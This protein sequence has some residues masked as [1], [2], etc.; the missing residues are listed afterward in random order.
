MRKG[1]PKELRERAVSCLSKGMSFR[2]VSKLLDISVFTLQRWKKLSELGDICPL[3][4][5]VRRSKKH[6]HQAI[7][8]YVKEHPDAYLHEIA[9]IFDAGISSIHY[10][11]KKYGL[12]YKKKFNL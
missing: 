5:D 6:N 3:R 10:I 12:T 9:I 11:C 1:Y 8:D 4:E 2:A 7:C